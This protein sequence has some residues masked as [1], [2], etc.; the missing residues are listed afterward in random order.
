MSDLVPLDRRGKPLDIA[1]LTNYLVSKEAEYI[2]GETIRV[3]GGLI[4]YGPNES[5][6]K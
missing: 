1:N 3:D 6:G 4:L 2:T 5:K